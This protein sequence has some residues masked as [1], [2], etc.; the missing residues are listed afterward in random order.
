MSNIW[1]I[2]W[3]DIIHGLIVTILAALLYGLL[4]LLP[5]FGLSAELQAL[6]ATFVGYLIKNLTMDTQGKVLGKI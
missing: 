4:Q 1:R 2:S 6:L 3:R 5:T